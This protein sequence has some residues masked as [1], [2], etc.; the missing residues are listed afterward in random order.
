M[1]DS[2]SREINYLRIS[3]TEKNNLRYVY[4]RY[5]DYKN[6]ENT[7]EDTICLED[8]KFII[9]TFKELGV[10]KVKFVGGE[11]LLYPYLKELIY[12]AKYE[13]HMEDVSITT[14]GQSFCEKA[15]DLR[16]AGLDRV[17]IN[18]DSLKE[19][20]YRGVT[21]GGSLSEALNS[22]NTCLRL[23]LPVKI[24]CTLIDEFNVDEIGDFIELSRY[25]NID[26]R[27]VELSPYEND[28]EFCKAH[29]ANVGELVKNYMEIDKYD[30]EKESRTK[31]YNIN[32]LKGRVGTICASDCD[33]CDDCNKIMITHDGFLRLCLFA[34]EE[35]DLRN[36]LHKPIMFKEVIRQLM[37]EKQ[38]S[39]INL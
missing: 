31:Y 32:N 15:L 4:Y 16:E 7:I 9:K 39:Y 36:Y 29:Y 33:F 11:P 5:E 17:N 34:D 25:N 23:K 12:F 24:N 20:K 6:E 18:I 35:I 30:Y 1:K 14:N 3:L 21:D 10:N 38:K 2:Y 37:R 8:F 13:C 28:K 27:F 19:Y 26:V 22:L